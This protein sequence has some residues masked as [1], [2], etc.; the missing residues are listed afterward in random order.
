MRVFLSWLSH[1]IFIAFEYNASYSICGM[2]I[3][4]AATTAMPLN[5]TL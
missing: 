3:A 2:I 1:L 4:E 5:P